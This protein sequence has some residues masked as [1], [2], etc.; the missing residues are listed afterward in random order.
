VNIRNAIFLFV[1]CI[2]LQANAQKQL[3]LLK[4]QKVI[5]RLNPGDEIIFSLKGKKD[6]LYSY[7]NNLSDTSLLAHNTVVPFHKIDRIYFKHSSYANM[8]GGLLVMGG[9]GIFALDQLNTLVIQGEKATLDDRV[10]TISVSSLAVGL[11][12]MLIRKKSQRLKPPYR[13]L[14]IKEGSVFYTEPPKQMVIEN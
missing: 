12:M 5:L 6:V 9:V 10:V 2:S 1:F 11:P 4:K 3:V 8:I 14:T 13:L 7:I